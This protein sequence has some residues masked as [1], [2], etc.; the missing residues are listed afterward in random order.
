MWLIAETPKAEWGPLIGVL[1]SGS[2]V[3]CVC[4]CVCVCECVRVLSFS[5]AVK[6]TDTEFPV[7]LIV[8]SV[9]CKAHR[10][11]GEYMMNSERS[12]A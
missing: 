9:R 3:E 2:H 4:V 8:L 11:Q 7:G 12:Y 5:G 10:K 6:E 1:Q